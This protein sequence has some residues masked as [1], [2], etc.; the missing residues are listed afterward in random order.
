MTNPVIAE[1]YNKND[2]DRKGYDQFFLS[3]FVWPFAKLNATVHDSFTCHEY[4]NSAP[5]PTKRLNPKCFVGSPDECEES[6]GI[7]SP[8]KSENF[9]PIDCRPHVHLDWFYC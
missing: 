3:D 5:F 9:C 8:L 7:L 6:L 4:V 2:R 1:N